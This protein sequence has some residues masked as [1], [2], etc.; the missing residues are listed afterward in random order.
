M[1]NVTHAHTQCETRSQTMTGA[2]K[3]DNRSENLCHRSER[4]VFILLYLQNQNFSSHIYSQISVFRSVSLFT[5]IEWKCFVAILPESLFYSQFHYRLGALFRFVYRYSFATSIRVSLGI[6]S[7]REN[8]ESNFQ[9]RCCWWWCFYCCCIRSKIDSPF[10][11]QITQFSHKIF[12]FALALYLLSMCV[13]R[14]YQWR[15]TG[16]CVAVQPYKWNSTLSF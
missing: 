2:N 3:A 14:V 10:I 4:F 16:V 1:F 6:N 8:F 7:L 5:A 11:L 9:L 15:C 12:V 13:C